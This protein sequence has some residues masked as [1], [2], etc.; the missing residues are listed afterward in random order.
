MAKEKHSTFHQV[1]GFE[2]RLYVSFFNFRLRC[3]CGV[4]RDYFL[5]RAES[6]KSQVFELAGDLNG[7]ELTKPYGHSISQ[8]CFTFCQAHILNYNC[9]FHSFRPLPR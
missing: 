2:T 9:I 4:G 3:A 7:A 1:E 8:T 6:R 5:Q